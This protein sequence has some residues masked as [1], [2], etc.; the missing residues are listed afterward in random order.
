MSLV[1]INM[2]YNHREYSQD[3]GDIY[4][5]GCLYIDFVEAIKEKQLQFCSETIGAFMSYL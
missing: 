4:H 1:V 3:T 2:F 5:Q